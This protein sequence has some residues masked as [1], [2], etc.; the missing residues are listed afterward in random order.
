MGTCHTCGKQV[1]LQEDQTKCGDCGSIIY[2]RCWNCKNEFDT[3]N[4]KGNKRK[5]CKICGYFYCPHCNVCGEDCGKNEW[6]SI[7][8]KT[9]PTAS[10]EQYK[11]II[12]FFEEI[13]TSKE[14]KMCHKNIPITYAK[15]RIKSLLGRMEGFRVKNEVDQ[16]AFIQR[17]DKIT[18]KSIGTKLIINRIRENGSYGQ[19]YRD[20]FNLL[21]CLGKL[22]LNW[23]KKEDGESY[24]EYTRIDGVPCSYLNLKNLIFYECPKCKTKYSKDVISCQ[25]CTYKKGKRIGEYYKIKGRLN[26]SHTCQMYRGDFKKECGKHKKGIGETQGIKKVWCF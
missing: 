4:D 11:I 9:F 2:Y 7:L 26:N 24:A 18:D 21:V 15:N 25:N 16:E 8:K 1:T 23:I 12:D 5:E 6:V 20:A 22:S 19:E 13:K 10:E 3:V 14:R 17:I